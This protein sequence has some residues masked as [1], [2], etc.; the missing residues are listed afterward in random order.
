[1]PRSDQ[2]KILSWSFKKRVPFLI[3]EIRK[4]TILFIPEFADSFHFRNVRVKNGLF[5][6]L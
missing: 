2:K 4:R 1:M 5:L 6:K 3:Q